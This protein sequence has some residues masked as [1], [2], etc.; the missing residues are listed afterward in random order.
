V[1]S[2][3]TAIPQRSSIMKLQYQTYW[4]DPAQQD[5]NLKWIDGFYGDMYGP[6]GPR[7]DGTLDGAYVNYPD[8]DLP[9]WQHLYYQG[10]YPRLQR[11]KARWDPRNVFHHAQSI[12]LP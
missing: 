5:A 6:G 8:V 9:D 4:T 7:P 12:E 10:G 11:T 1:P 3:A 2:D